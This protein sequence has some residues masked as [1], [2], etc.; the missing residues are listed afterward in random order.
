MSTF[1]S[2]VLQRT[3][4]LRHLSQDSEQ[5]DD[6]VDY[7][8]KS[9]PFIQKYEEQRTKIDAS[10]SDAPVPH[11]GE[12]QTPQ[13]ATTVAGTID[14]FVDVATYHE[15]GRVYDE[16]LAMVEGDTEAI[17]RICVPR[18][19]LINRYHPGLVESTKRKSTPKVNS[20]SVSSGMEDSC[21][22]CGG[23]YVFDVSQSMCIC[24]ACGICSQYMEGS[25]RNLSYSEQVERGNKKTFTY[26][27]I[28]HFCETLASVQGKQ[29]TTIPD[30]VRLGYPKFYEANNYILNIIQGKQRVVIPQELED[31]LIHMFIKI[32]RP[33][34]TVC[35]KGRRNFLR[36]HFIIYKMLELLGDEGEPYLH[37]FPLLKSTNK[38]AQHDAVWK[39]ICEEVGFKFKPTI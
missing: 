34:E 8:L 33:F 5:F 15:T 20:F 30:E 2:R 25:T 29:K 21:E 19:R 6:H 14:N 7:L 4:K 1:E 35:D 17:G 22:H 24:T 18:D 36:Y 31:K 9:L 38:L 32:Q 11:P 27:R 16:Y 12:C 28:S 26:K 39:R 13:T 37:L 3:K 23:R 10:Q